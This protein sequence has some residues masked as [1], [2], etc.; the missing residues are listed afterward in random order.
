MAPNNGIGTMTK[1]AIVADDEPANR[2]FMV[3]LIQMAGF[4]VDGV[5]TGAEAIQAAKSASELALALVD[6][7]MPDAKGLDIILQLRA[8]YPQALLIMATMHDHRELIDE[9]FCAGIDVFLVKPHGFMELF[10]RLQ[11][12]GAG[13]TD[14]LRRIIIDQYGP[15]PYKTGARK[16][17]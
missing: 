17:G 16:T 11:E 15:R 5:G 2:D 6:H 9:A 14:N 1:Y 4:K 12:T 7:E 8:Q 13:A 3:R 10:R